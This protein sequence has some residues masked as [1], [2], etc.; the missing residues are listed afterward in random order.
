MCQLVQGFPEILRGIS[1]NPYVTRYAPPFD[2]FEVDRCIL[3]SKE[4][5]LFAPV[6]GPS[7][8]IIVAGEGQLQ[9]GSVIEERVTKGDVYFVPAHSQISF[10]ASTDKPIHLYRSGVNNRIFG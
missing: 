2:E 3:P 6:P 8:F 4:S 1:L 10:S 7:I 9:M 5:V